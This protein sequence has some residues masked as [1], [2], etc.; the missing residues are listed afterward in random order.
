TGT[1]TAVSCSGSMP[2]SCTITGTGFS[3]LPGYATDPHTTWTGVGGPILTN[4]AVFCL[5]L[6]Y[7]TPFDN[8]VPITNINS[9]TSLTVNLAISG[10]SVNM[11]WAWAT[12]GSYAIYSSSYP[13]AISV[14]ASTFTAADV[15]G[16][17]NGDTLDQ[18]IAYNMRLEGLQITQT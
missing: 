8:C 11:G 14:A 15:S 2:A 5:P 13:T 9:D 7:S 3:A 4:N 18:V 6:S 10:P 17:G 16:I 1:Y 12:S